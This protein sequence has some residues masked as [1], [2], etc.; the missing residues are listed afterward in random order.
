MC[1]LRHSGCECQGAPVTATVSAATSLV[2]AAAAQVGS[3]T[4]HGQCSESICGCNFSNPATLA[5]GQLGV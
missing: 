4:A 3:L 2:E 1:D 5:T